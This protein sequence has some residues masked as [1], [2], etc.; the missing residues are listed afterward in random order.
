MSEYRPGGNRRI[1]RVLAPGF[2]EGLQSLSHDELLDRRSDAEQ[3][4]ADLSYQRRLL[5]GRLDLLRA[6]QARRSGGEA[7]PAPA[8]S[9][10]DAD[11]VA[12]LTKVLT[13]ERPPG[14]GKF[15][16]RTA[17]LTPSRV[18][19]HRR[20]AEAAAADVRHSDLS[21]LDDAELADAVAKLGDLERRTSTSRRS[22]QGI[23]D[24]LSA[25][26]AARVET[27]TLI[28]DEG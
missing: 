4:E 13:D 17:G 14:P 25:E 18:G 2:A 24:A 1:D 28:S 27:G 8:G 9:R 15:T 12:A 5:Q 26:I 22:V 3:E 23:V 7:P 19:E 16:G 11:I 20:E 6:E 10:S 21:G